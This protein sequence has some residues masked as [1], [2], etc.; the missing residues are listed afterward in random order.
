[1]SKFITCITIAAL[2]I[3]STA[4]LQPASLPSQ[5]TI[6]NH[7]TL[8][9]VKQQHYSSDE[10]RCLADNIYHEAGDQSDAGKIAIALVTLT[11]T[12]NKYYPSTICEVVKEWRWRNGR[13]VCQ[14]SWFC[15]R[16]KAPS[17]DIDRV[18]YKRSRI[19]AAAIL[20]HVANDFDYSTAP[21][22]Y[23][24]TYVKPSW[25]RSKRMIRVA[26]VGQHIFY[27]EIR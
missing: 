15:M 13:K 24:A 10:L 14:F 9:I 20:E 23:H 2:Y 8:T 19:I 5:S 4:T 26:R 1:M 11:R 7:A 6:V 21:T 3:I 18:V 16:I 25:S 27:K 22:N 12:K 17:N